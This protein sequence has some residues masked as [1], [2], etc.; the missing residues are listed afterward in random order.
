MELERLLD[1][2]R[3]LEER[4]AAVY[5]I[6]AASARIDPPLCALW[7]DL[8]R[9]E[10]AHARSLASAKGGIATVTG[11]RPRVNGWEKAVDEIE[12]RLA[13]AERLGP[14]A[15]TDRQLSAALA[16]EMTELEGLRHL[17]LELSRCPEDEA[18]GA[19]A[20][21]LADQAARFSQDLQVTL[22]AALLRA[23]ARARPRPA[24]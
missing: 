6:Y 7:T 10:E 18:R 22:Q 9:D 11:R 23:R 17:L 8:A 14:D 4:A 19:H 13:A 16:L 2:A 20:E 15:G 1:R 12:E 21:R 3:Q 5:R 24:P